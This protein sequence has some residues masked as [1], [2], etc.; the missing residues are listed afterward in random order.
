MRKLRDLWHEYQIW[1]LLSWPLKSCQTLCSCR[2]SSWWLATCILNLT[3]HEWSDLVFIPQIIMMTCDM[4]AQSLWVVITSQLIMAHDMR[5]VMCDMTHSHAR[6][7]PFTRETWLSHT[8][9]RL[10]HMCDVPRS[11]ARYVIQVWH[12]SCVYVTGLV[13]MRAMAHNYEPWRTHTWEWVMTSQ[14]IQGDNTTRPQVRHDALAREICHTSVTWLLHMWH[15]S[16]MCDMTRPCVTRELCHTSVTWL[17][18]M[19]HDSLMCDVMHS[20]V[21]H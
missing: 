15:D 13:D 16:L 20:H 8:L 3:T 4:N 17:V 11:H 19:W 9:T 6:H 21:N 5:Y 7:D 18:H 1:Q 12:H 2:K 10:A 14:Q